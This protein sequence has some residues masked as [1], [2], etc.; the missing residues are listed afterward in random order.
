[1]SFHLHACADVN[2]EKVNI[3]V[4][5]DEK[6]KDVTALAQ[7]LEAVF[8]NEFAAKQLESRLFAIDFIVFYDDPLQKW[9]P[10]EQT[11]QLTEFAQVYCFQTNLDKETIREIPQPFKQV[12]AV[13]RGQRT[14]HRPGV[15]TVSIDKAQAVFNEMDINSSGTI[16]LGEMQLAFTAAGIDFNEETIARLFEKSDANCDG[17][18]RWEEFLIFAELFPNTVETLYWRLCHFVGER[19]RDSLPEKLKEHRR[20]EKARREELARMEQERKGMEETLRTE[21][22]LARERDPRRRYLEDEE[23]DLINKEFALQFHRDMV[24]QAESQFSET[25]VRFDHAAM[26][27]G[28][29]RRARFL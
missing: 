15:G 27:Q 1:M 25:A 26:R 12:S 19:S 28:S 10:L 18:I 21:Q 4:A 29:P 7:E 3:D 11:A 9:K 24:I 20:T 8:R 22:K 6:P 13:A 5:F 16:E 14:V 23:Q 2:G 17:V